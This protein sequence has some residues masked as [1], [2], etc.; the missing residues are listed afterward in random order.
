MVSLASRAG[1]G[2]RVSRYRTPAFCTHSSGLDTILLLGAGHRG[3]AGDVHGE[4]EQHAE[5]G[6]DVAADVEDAGVVP[7]PSLSYARPR[8]GSPDL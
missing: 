5:V 8:D 1:C 6:Q 2:P 3:V 4:D 7:A